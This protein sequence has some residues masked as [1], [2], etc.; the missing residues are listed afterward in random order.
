MNQRIDIITDKL[1]YGIQVEEAKVKKIVADL[2]NTIPMKA[3][4]RDFICIGHFHK[5]SD[6]N[7]SLW[8]NARDVTA[9]IVMNISNIS[10]PNKNLVL[11]SGT[12]PSA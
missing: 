3:K 7:C 8:A 12:K 6:P 5:D 9:I 1:T 11:P 4:A 2:I 10:L